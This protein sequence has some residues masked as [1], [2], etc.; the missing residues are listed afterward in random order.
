MLLI[1]NNL[2][3]L[4]GFIENLVGALDITQNLLRSSSIKIWRLEELLLELMVGQKSEIKIQKDLIICWSEQEETVQSAVKTKM[5]TSCDIVKDESKNSVAKKTIPCAVKST[6]SED[7]RQRN[8]LI[9]GLE[10]N[11]EFHVVKRCG[12]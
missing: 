7:Q 5:V 9:F 1:Q 3:V 11:L 12:D 2:N 6:V 10:D 8:V 4:A